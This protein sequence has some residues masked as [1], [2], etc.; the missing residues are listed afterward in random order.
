MPKELDNTDSFTSANN[1]TVTTKNLH[2]CHKTSKKYRAFII[3]L[4]CF[5]AFSMP[6]LYL[7][8]S[9]DWKVLAVSSVFFCFNL[10]SYVFCQTPSDIA[11][12]LKSINQND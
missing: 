10:L 9:P 6:Y 4:I 11:L 1:S 2:K 7:N 8:H 3:S 12:I 5:F